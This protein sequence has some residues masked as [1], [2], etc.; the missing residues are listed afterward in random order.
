VA[1]A[2]IR[3]DESKHVPGRSAADVSELVR[4]AVADIPRH[5]CALVS[6][7][8]HKVVRTYRRP[9]RLL[10]THTDVCTITVVE[11][12]LG[13]VVTTVGA[14]L[15]QTRTAILAALDATSVPAASAAAH[16]APGAPGAPA[17]ARLT[18]AAPPP[19]PL[20]APE[21]RAAAVAGP[22]APSP[23]PSFR[24]QP[25]PPRPDPAPAA[26]TIV[27]PALRLPDGRVVPLIRGTV[28]VGRNPVASTTDARPHL[29]TIAD[30]TRT[31]SKSHFAVGFDDRGLWIEDRH[32]TN[33]TSVTDRRGRRMD[34]PPG[35]PTRIPADVLVTFGD[36]RAT[37]AS[38]S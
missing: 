6:P 11:A 27:V 2:G 17:P 34:L 8:T 3:V 23:M 4:V 31:V 1:G 38:T 10:T 30:D 36:Q 16:V 18:P 12:P 5:Q 24:P 28:V 14:L 21:T 33:G 37:I 7:G 26:P 19:A 22:P 9:F 15:P 25:S 13:V 29:V 35:R 32:S 20:P